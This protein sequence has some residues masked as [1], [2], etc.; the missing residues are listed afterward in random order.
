MALERANTL[1]PAFDTECKASILIIFMAHPAACSIREKWWT[2]SRTVCAMCRQISTRFGQEYWIL[3]LL[4]KILENMF[5]F[6]CFSGTDRMMI[7]DIVSLSEHSSLILCS[8][9]SCPIF[10]KCPLVYLH[11]NWF[12]AKKYR[13]KKKITVS[14]IKVSMLQNSTRSTCCSTPTYARYS[15]PTRS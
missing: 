11:P 4:Q 2:F 8:Y 15:T 13:F 10:D 5:Q 9:L 3:H 12:K 6:I 1:C 7:Y 14:R